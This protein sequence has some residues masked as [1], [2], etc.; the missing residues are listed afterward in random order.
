MKIAGII[1]EYNPFHL[2]HK[3][4]LEKIKEKNLYTIAIISSSFTQ[5]GTPSIIN[6]FDKTEI[7]LANGV[8]LVL[9][10]PVVFSTQSAE[11][12]SKGAITILNSLGIINYLYFGSEDDICKLKNISDKLEDN[13]QYIKEKINNFSKKYSFIQAREKSFYFLSKEEIEIIKKPNNILAIEYIKALKQIKSKIEPMSIIRKS[14][15]HNSTNIVS[16]YTSASN[17]RKHIVNNEFEKIKNTV[18]EYSK[19]II[20]N[21]KPNVLNNYFDMFKYKILSEKIN[22]SKYVDFEEG[23]DN[24]FFKFLDNKNIEDFISNVSSKRYT[25]SRISRLIT[26]ILLDIDR[27][28]IENSYNSNYVRILGCNEKGFEILKLLKEK[29]INYIDKFKI[30]D[31]FNLSTKNILTKEILATNMYNIMV[32]RPLNE[33]FT[34]GVITKIKKNLD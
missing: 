33:D 4:Q 15:E 24:R 5:R 28:L 22:Y 7:A 19:H 20:E 30:D 21:S 8:D 32:D 17:I 34:H 13:S 12:F 16:N 11:I 26:S 31:N 27:E 9:E 18:P 14:V 6:K 3:Y 23:L 10:L 29:N 1:A 2:G 25:K